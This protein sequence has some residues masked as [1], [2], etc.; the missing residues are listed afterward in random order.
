MK[1]LFQVICLTATCCSPTD[2]SD[3]SFDDTFQGYVTAFNDN[4]YEDFLNYIPSQ[5]FE[6]V[7]KERV[8]EFYKE[9]QGTIGQT[10]IQDYEFIKRG[11]ILTKGDSIFR[12][13]RYKSTIVN[14]SN[15]DTINHSAFNYLANIY[16]EGNIQYDSLERLYIIY[17]VK[18]L[19]F[20][21]TNESNWRFLEYDSTKENKLT[22]RLVPQDILG[23]L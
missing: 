14:Y 12:K 16:G 22:K 18:D 7:S 6:T 11:P 13:I 21:R 1:R 3:K 23:R 10:R 19:I 8:I 9:M 17:Q 4:Q 20:M 2:I 15:R 5:T